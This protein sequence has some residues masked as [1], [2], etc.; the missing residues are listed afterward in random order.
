MK[1]EG[2]PCKIHFIWIGGPMPGWASAN[3]D[4]FRRLNPEHEIAVHGEEA[5]LDDYRPIYERLDELAPKADLVR[6]SVLEREGGWYFDADTWPLRPVADI[7]HA[8]RPDGRQMIIGEQYDSKHRL[9]INNGAIGVAAGWPG[10]PAFRRML[11][12]TEPR[13]RVALGPGLLTRFCRQHRDLVEI[14]ARPWFYGVG[15]DWTGKLYRQ[16]RRGRMA[17]CRTVADT[18]GQFPF[19][20]HLWAGNKRV[21]LCERPPTGE[22]VF[23]SGER[24]ALVACTMRRMPSETS[25]LWSGVIRGLV[26]LGFRVERHSTE[27]AFDAAAEIPDVIVTW[28]GMRGA[29]GDLVQTAKLFDIPVIRLEHGFYQR[30]LYSQADHEGILHRASWRRELRNP[31]PPEGAERLARFYPDGITA[32]R[33][34]K[35]YILVIGQVAGDSQMFDSPIQSS[36]PLQRLVHRATKGMSVPVFFRPHPAERSPRQSL[37][38]QLP[39]DDDARGVY[40]RTKHGSGLDQALAGA[41]FVITINSNT[42]VEALAAGVPALAFGPHLGIEAGVV[43]QTSEQTLR[44]DILEMLAG[45]R[46]EQAAV[47]NFLRHLA[48]RQWTPDELA[49]AEVMGKLLDAAGVLYEQP[50][51][52][53]CC[54][55]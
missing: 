16:V 41:A 38:K 55:A 7:E 49:T 51:A 39:R 19:S 22:N 12:A 1:R 45:W 23:G 37:L 9:W 44:N 53:G 52:D 27:R 26:A 8:Y 28:N 14:V 5:L 17:A 35:G 20:I 31:A 29:A 54:V 47:E 46:P 43:R 32:M 10:W 42:I 3:V 24:T 25:D 36:I 18:D 15:P 11:L 40:V 50:V 33:K 4:E 34:R 13:D 30:R 2:F 6:Y 21:D 48:C